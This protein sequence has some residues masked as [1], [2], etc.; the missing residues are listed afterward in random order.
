[1][2]NDKILFKMICFSD[3]DRDYQENLYQQKLVFFGKKD[4]VTKTEY[5]LRKNK[6]LYLEVKSAFI[7][8][9]CELIEIENLCLFENLQTAIGYYRNCSNSND[10]H[11]V[12]SMVFL[13]I[14]RKKIFGSSSVKF[15]IY[16][17][18]SVLEIYNCLPIILYPRTIVE[19]NRIAE[20]NIVID[21]L[22][23]IMKE[24]NQISYTY[25]TVFPDLRTSELLEIL[26]NQKVYLNR[27]FNVE[28]C[29]LYGS[30]AREDYTKY[31]DVDMI[32]KST[33]KEVDYNGLK[34]YLQELLNRRIDL[35]VDNGMLD[36][37]RMST[38]FFTNRLKVF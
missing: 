17:M 14:L 33:T 34:G 26:I 25:N 22:I 36:K 1:M 31:S 23:Q 28:S 20:G 9:D 35:I 6:M 32:V 19:L 2:Y 27:E 4:P 30:Y 11:R 15:A 16:C 21:S 29:E 10:P 24:L 18:N 7:K 8:S 37:K 5:N 13:Y 3:L 12:A 38:D